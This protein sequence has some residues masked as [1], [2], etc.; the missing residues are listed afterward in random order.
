MKNKKENQKINFNYIEEFKTNLQTTPTE[1]ELKTIF[2]KKYFN[3]I[4]RKEKRNL[5]GCIFE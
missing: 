5:G 3:Y 4:K 1:K 2:N